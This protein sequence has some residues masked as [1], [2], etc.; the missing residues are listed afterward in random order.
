MYMKCFLIIRDAYWSLVVISCSGMQE[1]GEM[2]TREEEGS[3]ALWGSGR[4]LRPAGSFSGQCEKW[5]LL[6]I[7][8][9]VLPT[10]IKHTV[11]KEN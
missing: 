7:T 10:K 2:R 6:I 4:R 11:I 9:R 8:R 3:V 1:S 5:S